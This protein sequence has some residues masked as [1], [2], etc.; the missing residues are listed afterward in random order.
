[1]TSE[2]VTAQET[3]IREWLETPLGRSLLAH[4]ARLVEQA[5]EGVFGELACSSAAGART[6]TCCATPAPSARH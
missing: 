4:E 2:A 5:L 1:M 3:G 6:A